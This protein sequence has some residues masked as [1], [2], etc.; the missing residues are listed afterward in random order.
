MV[1]QESLDSVILR[2]S[3]YL[4]V[5][6]GT[7]LDQLPGDVLTRP[8]VRLVLLRRHHVVAL[9]VPVSRVRVVSCGRSVRDARRRHDPRSLARRLRPAQHRVHVVSRVRGH[10][11]V[12]P[13]H[14]RRQTH[15][16]VVR[17]YAAQVGGGG[18]G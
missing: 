15:R 6:A 7:V 17:L 10:V 8:R 2:P 9:P 16:A 1:L 5:F 13:R 14:G 11:A 4:A 18:A 12:A 3:P